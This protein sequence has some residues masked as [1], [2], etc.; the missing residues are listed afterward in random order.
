MTMPRRRA[1]LLNL[2]AMALL[3]LAQAALLVLVV[4]CVNRWFVPSG[5]YLRP[6][7]GT[8]QQ[9]STTVCRDTTSV[10]RET[11]RR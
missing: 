1:D 9:D 11:L 10:S 8:W 6:C 7:V 3:V 4:G 5:Q 2:A